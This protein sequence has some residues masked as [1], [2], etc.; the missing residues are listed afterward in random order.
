MTL[1]F[2]LAPGTNNELTLTESDIVDLNPVKTHTGKGDFRATLAGLFDT[3]SPYAQRQD[4][5]NINYDGTTL[6]T[7]YLL[8]VSHNERTANTIIRGDGIAKRLEET[9]PDY[10]SNGGPIVYTDISLEDALKDYW[11]R[12][13]FDNFSVVNQTTDSV[14]TDE[15]L[16]SADTTSEF[17]DILS[18]PN[19]TPMFVN[20]GKLK[21]A[22]SSF[23]R[24]AENADNS[25]V[26][27]TPSGGNSSNGKYVVMSSS[28]NFINFSETLNYTIP[29][30]DVK[31]AMRVRYPN[32]ANPAYEMRID[33]NTVRNVSAG[34]ESNTSYEWVKSISDPG[35]DLTAG[36]HSVEIEVTASGDPMEVDGFVFYDNAFNHTFDNTVDTN[37]YLSGPEDYP[38]PSTVEFNN[39]VVS[40][41]VSDATV[42]ITAND[43][44]NGQKIQVSFDEGNTYIPTDGTEDNTTSVTADSNSAG[45]DV[46]GRVGLDG[47]GT[48][49]TATPTTR[50]KGQEIDTWELLSSGDDLVVIDK[51]ELSRNHFDNL[52]TLHT[53][54]GFLW[55]ISHDSGDIANMTVTSFLE[56]DE[57]RPKPDGFDNPRNQNKEIQSDTYFNS[58]FLQGAKDAN[59]DR[60][61]AEIKD[62][63][64]INNDGRE[65]SPGVLRD[66]TVTTEAGAL[67]RAQS[68]LNIAL[69]QNEFVGTVNSSEFE[70]SDPGF[71]R[72]VDF[73]NGE[74]DKTVE[75]VSVSE[76]ANSIQ[77]NWR[78]SLPNQLAE[79]IEALRQDAKRV[80][81]QV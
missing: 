55:V 81:D 20:A 27:S 77:I 58:I 75:E 48:R 69:A 45:R 62:Q 32:G 43:T 18:I 76:S 12:T 22:Q 19:Q 36:S 54:G 73:G 4:R 65:I 78:F 31:V 21:L 2:V 63:T 72:P 49:T 38:A 71:A 15:Q 13:P 3:V 7:G 11:P 41:N 68:L 46:R 34:A 35:T 64:A 10:E 28:G 1:T 39:E 79:D 70:F 50:H 47:F 5:I 60:P 52:K 80:G 33:G 74:K 67:F 61:T 51:L 25:L 37:G 16:Q 29:N 8:D 66:T 56:G 42:N 30:S 6:F 53:Y 9:R 14:A 57:T 17:N 59:G 24:E 44:S 23:F 26:N 40:Y